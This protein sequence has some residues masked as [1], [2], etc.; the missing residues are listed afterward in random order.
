MDNGRL[1]RLLGNHYGKRLMH[2]YEQRGLAHEEARSIRDQYLSRFT[3]A[4]D[5]ADFGADNGRF[6]SYLNCLSGVIPY[7][8][9][10][11]RGLTQEEGVACYDYLAQPVRRFAAWLWNTVDLL[12]NGYQIVAKNVRDDLTGP[13]GVCWTTE[14]IRDDEDAFEYRCRTCLY[15]DICCEQG[16]PEAIHLFCN[17]DHH[18]WDGLRRHVRFVRYGGVGERREDGSLSDGLSSTESGCLCHDAFVRVR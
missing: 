4:M 3:E 2:W 15:Y 8:M 6:S 17:H 7:A 11:E 9:A 1:I 18:A 16:Y 10:R 12:P 5:A 13:K 14:I